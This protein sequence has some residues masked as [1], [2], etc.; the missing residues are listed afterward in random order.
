[1][2][3]YIRANSFRLV[4]TAAPNLPNQYSH[5]IHMRNPVDQAIKTMTLGAGVVGL[6]V[7]TIFQLL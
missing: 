7:L 4:P 5:P 6:I 1:M 3:A 2:C